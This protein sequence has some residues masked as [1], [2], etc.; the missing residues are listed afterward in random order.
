MKRGTRLRISLP[1]ISY[2]VALDDLATS[3]TVD[4]RI[5]RLGEIKR[6]LEAAIAAVH[7]LQEEARDRKTEADQLQALIAK[8]QEDKS[9]AESLLKLPEE[10][11]IRLVGRAT[12]KG[13]VRGLIEGAIIGFATGALSSFL[14]WYFT[15]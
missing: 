2:E 13:R 1:F 10:S 8:L 14:V 6:D 9:A 4:A 5:A 3:D 11:F 12:S 7:G 15:R